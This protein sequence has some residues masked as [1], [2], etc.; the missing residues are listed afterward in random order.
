MI[1][2]INTQKPEHIAAMA[3]A[4]I[5]CGLLGFLVG[6]GIKSLIVSNQA[7]K[8]LS[9]KE[10]AEHDAEYSAEFVQQVAAMAAKKAAENK[11][12]AADSSAQENNAGAK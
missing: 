1:F 5:G 6:E 11:N 2:E 3:G 10:Q 7:P 9:A 12:S 4:G 8:Q